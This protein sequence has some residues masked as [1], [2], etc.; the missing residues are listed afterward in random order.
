[1]EYSENKQISKKRVH[2]LMDR[3]SALNAEH[4]AILQKSERPKEQ[5]K[6][7]MEQPIEPLQTEKLISRAQLIEGLR[8]GIPMETQ[9]KI[10]KHKIER[11]ADDFARNIIDSAVS[12]NS[13]SNI[14]RKLYKKRQDREFFQKQLQDRLNI[15]RRAV[16]DNLLHR[17]DSHDSLMDRMIRKKLLERLQEKDNENENKKTETRERTRQRT[18][19]RMRIRQRQ[20]MYIR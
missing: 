2:G 13:L 3:L 7:D 20:N 8:M 6:Q 11:Y 5:P 9:R 4:R 14:N 18:R 12:G 15:S 10:I 19:N 16:I 17:D 1:M